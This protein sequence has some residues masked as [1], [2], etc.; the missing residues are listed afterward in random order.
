MRNVAKKICLAGD[1][2]GAVAALESLSNKFKEI[3]V[4]T[5]DSDLKD[6]AYKAG[7]KEKSDIYTVD[8]DL[9]ICAGYKPIIANDFVK[10]KK[11]VNV[12]YSLL[13]KYRGMHSIVWAILNGEKKIGLSIHEMNQDIDDGP[14]IDQYVIDYQEETA[15]ELME[16]CNE[17]V[18]TNLGDVIS[19]YLCGEIEVAIQNFKEATWVCKRNLDDCLINFDWN[20]AFL[21]RFFKALVCPY[22]L[23]RIS[24]RDELYEVLKV[25]FIE[26]NYYMTNG[27]VVNID[28]QGAWIKVQDGLMIVS[29]LKS[30]KTG[31][32]VLAKNL[33]KI[34]ARL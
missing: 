6:F 2:W 16:I 8:A 23:P 7:L 28:S 30:I 9:Y 4:V 18:R 11:I 20:M 24:F 10:Q 14:I 15:N 19:S 32:T 22:P 34:G 3:T 25:D 1:G 27:R 13:P 29:E 26:Q 31:Q 5:N 33:L 17:Y 21:K 12:H